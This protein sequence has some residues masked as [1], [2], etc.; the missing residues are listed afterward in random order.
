MNVV[1]NGA[2]TFQSFDQ[3][4]H[5]LL[6]CCQNSFPGLWP[7]SGV[8]S[9]GWPVL[10]A[11]EFFKTCVEFVVRR[12]DICKRIASHP[13]GKALVARDDVAERSVLIEMVY[14]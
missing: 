14:F 10:G 11:P 9:I 13:N 7:K 12:T 5:S 4:G 3:S 2:C 6:I 8:P 1:A